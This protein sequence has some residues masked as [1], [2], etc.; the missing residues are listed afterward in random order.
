VKAAVAAGVLAATIWVPHV[1]ADAW[2]DSYDPATKTRF[3]RFGGGI[4]RIVGPFDWTDPLTGETLK[5]YRRDHDKERKSQWFAV[6]EDG[7][8][9]GRVD[10]S[11]WK[12]EFQRGESKFPLGLWTQG[13]TRVYPLTMIGRNSKR[14][15]PNFPASVTIVMERIDH[16]DGFVDHCLTF[17]WQLRMRDRLADNNAYTYCPGKGLTSLDDD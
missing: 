9:I 5:V 12:G 14:P 10:D 1:Q 16:R 4:K 15:I 2:S 3:V 6:R 7:T 17:R 13:E 11:R 8:G